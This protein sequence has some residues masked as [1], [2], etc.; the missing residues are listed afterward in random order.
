M[1]SSPRRM[2]PPDLSIETTPPRRAVRARGRSWLP[3]M[4]AAAALTLSVA[5]GV[6]GV[7]AWLD[8]TEPAPLPTVLTS[9]DPL[10]PPVGPRET[11]I[12]DKTIG[13]TSMDAMTLLIP[14]Q[15]VYAPLESHG[16]ATTTFRG[17]TIGEL[18]LPSDP[19]R[20][21]LFKDGAACTGTEGTLL[22]SGHVKN[23]GARGALYSL[24]A[25]PAGSIAYVRCADGTTTA[26]KQVEEQVTEKLSIPQGIYSAKG[27]RRLVVVTCGGS[28]GADGH[29]N[30]NIIQYF[31]PTT[32]VGAPS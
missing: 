26:W 10:T 20:L 6:T 23:N 7:R 18:V 22:I 4:A 30:S 17:V 19:A 2:L 29:Y 15:G 11:V 32:L 9:A 31:V 13:P 21:T 16:I 3:R 27:P 1:N 5:A 8:S 25:V 12:A 28:V 24:S 14:S